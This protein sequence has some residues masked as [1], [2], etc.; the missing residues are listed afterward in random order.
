MHSQWVCWMLRLGAVSSRF[1]T[2]KKT[3][4]CWL[5]AAPRNE[6]MWES[7]SKFSSLLYII[8]GP[9]APR[10]SLHHFYPGSNLP[11]P[12]NILKMPSAPS[13]HL[14]NRE[15][16]H[17]LSPEGDTALSCPRGSRFF[18]AG[19]ESWEIRAWVPVPQGRHW[20][21]TA[22]GMEASSLEFG[23][24]SFQS[25][26]LI[27]LEWV[28][29][30]ALC[31]P[32]KSETPREMGRGK[33]P[34][35]SCL[36]WLSCL[37]LPV[38]QK[39]QALGSAKL[40]KAFKRPFEKDE[41]HQENQKYNVN[42]FISLYVP[43]PAGKETLP[44]KHKNNFSGTTKL[45]HDSGE[46]FPS[47]APSTM[48]S[49]LTAA[50]KECCSTRGVLYSATDETPPDP[51]EQIKWHSSSLPTS[52]TQLM[53]S[54]VT[55]WE[56]KPQRAVQTIHYKFLKIP[57]QFIQFPAQGRECEAGREAEVVP[58]DVLPRCS[59]W[60]WALP[61]PATRTPGPLADATILKTNGKSGFF[62]IEHTFQSN[63][64][65]SGDWDC[66]GV[67]SRDNGSSVNLPRKYLG[68]LL[69]REK[70]LGRCQERSKLSHACF[71]FSLIKK[72]K[73]AVWKQTQSENN[74]ASGAKSQTQAL[75]SSCGQAQSKAGP[76][77]ALG[78]DKLGGIQKCWFPTVLLGRTTVT[79]PG[80]NLYI[81]LF[82]LIY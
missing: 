24:C 47:R 34:W 49:L 66:L 15:L 80:T 68:P 58:V 5:C 6:G 32:G 18:P 57:A 2:F 76:A 25:F 70:S 56:T 46:D 9:T 61:V 50:V 79:V 4:K 54:T 35:P 43:V 10:W 59:T 42:H 51:P 16:L 40:H 11:G 39:H 27:L 78:K 7:H 28:F 3:L 45:C 21:T 82:P 8:H 53:H 65:T 69:F 63:S 29:K 14:L 60:L 48:K 64:D 1:V 20:H 73:V 22:G 44:Q 52:E 19:K 74:S 72:N 75:S 17:W 71:I 62:T 23:T 33:V 77:L 41:K 37:T 36:T 30:R 38:L 26:K 81:I 31:T 12:K 67:L 55:T 13:W